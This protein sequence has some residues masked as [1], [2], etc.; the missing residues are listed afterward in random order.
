MRL[1][2][3]EYGLYL[4]LVARSRSEDNVTQVGSITMDQNWRITATGYN[5]FA[6]GYVPEPDLMADR[7][8]KARLINHAEVN[9]I[10]N[11][12]RDPYYLF[13]VFSPCFNCAKLI[14]GSKIKHVYFLSQYTIPKTGLPD[15]EYQ[16]LSKMHGVTFLE[17]TKHEKENILKRLKD[18]ELPF[19][20]GL[21]EKIPAAQP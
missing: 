1:S 17:A 15:L 2:K 7:E 9:T 5:G 6:S 11:S 8:S 16:S 10:L 21:V 19:I 13:S 4:A 14:V 20:A 12:S 18:S 3:V